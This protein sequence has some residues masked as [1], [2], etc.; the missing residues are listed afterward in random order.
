MSRWTHISSVIKVDIMKAT[1]HIKSYISK[2][3][4]GAPKITGSERDAD[5][6]FNVLSGFNESHWDRGKHTQYQTMAVITIVGDLRDKNR[7]DTVKELHDFKKYITGTLGWFIDDY[8]A[9]IHDELEEKS[10]VESDE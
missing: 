6:F 8:V 2:G 7:E 5:V 4:E 3:L 9:I 10:Y 1:K